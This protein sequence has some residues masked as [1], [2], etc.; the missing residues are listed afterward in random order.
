MEFFL[1]IVLILACLFYGARKGGVALGLLGGIGIVVLVFLFKLPPGK[2]VEILVRSEDPAVRAL[3][4]R[5]HP[6]IVHLAKLQALR[7]LEP[8]EAAP[9]ESATQVVRG[10]EVALPLAGLVDLAAERA[11]LTKDREKLQK[12]AAGIEAK[13]QNAGF[14]A[15]APPEV[16]AGAEGRLA[17]IK[18]DLERL[19]STLQRLGG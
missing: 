14:R 13:L 16:I 12:E 8:H 5:I 11:R 6:L 10:A 18:V 7:L 4:G 9:K 3:I 1:Q 17:E 2:R 19:L 15:K